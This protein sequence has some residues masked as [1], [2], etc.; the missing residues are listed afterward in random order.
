MNILK[1]QVLAQSNEHRKR[2]LFK[3][4]KEIKAWTIKVEKIKA[5]YHTMNMFKVHLNS[6]TAECWFPVKAIDDIRRALSIGE[7]SQHSFLSFIFVS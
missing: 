5:I 7:V 1:H 2:V 6:L 3:A 4:Q